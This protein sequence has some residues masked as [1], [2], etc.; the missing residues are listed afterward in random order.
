MNYRITQSGKLYSGPAARKSSPNLG[1]KNAGKSKSGH[2]Q[3]TDIDWGKI[4]VLA[5]PQPKI[6]FK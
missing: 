4:N 5:S 2:C 1:S 3:E 6:A